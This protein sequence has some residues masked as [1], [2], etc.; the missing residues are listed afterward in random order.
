MQADVSKL[1]ECEFWL[2]SELSAQ[3]IVHHPYRD[4]TKLRQ[5]FSMTGEQFSLCWSVVNDHYLT[6]LPL[7]HPPVIIAAAVAS[8]VLTIGPSQTGLQARRAAASQA[9]Q[10]S[11][12]SERHASEQ[13]QHLVR[14]LTESELNVE[15]VAECTQEFLS[16]YAA[17]DRYSERTCREQVG[18]LA[19]Y[20]S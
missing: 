20:R 12:G 10:S 3:L 6:A 14:W 5:E 18:R 19:K 9:E 2:I 17:L 4:L 11:Q 8:M 1:G 16:L 15:A 13:N 7:M